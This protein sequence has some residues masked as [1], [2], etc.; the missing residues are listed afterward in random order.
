[1]AS[2]NYTPSYL[3]KFSIIL[4]VP[5]LVGRQHL[6]PQY[7]NFFT[8]KF[9]LGLLLAVSGQVICTSI[10]KDYNNEFSDLG[11]KYHVIDECPFLSAVEL[12]TVW[13]NSGNCQLL[14]IGREHFQ[15]IQS[16][17]DEKF[18]LHRCLMFHSTPYF[19]DF[20]SFWF[21]SNT[22]CFYDYDECDR[23]EYDNYVLNKVP[24][25]IGYSDR[26]LSIS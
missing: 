4:K 9:N 23:F 8:Y 22:E 19:L 26:L 14:S 10:L 2:E 17:I 11:I 15:S 18:R 5:T 6:S 13:N 25:N 12:H 16:L 20:L 3:H 1:M 7:K 21:L 24:S